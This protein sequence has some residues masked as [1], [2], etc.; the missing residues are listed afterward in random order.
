MALSTLVLEGTGLSATGPTYAGLGYPSGN[1]AGSSAADA[2]A[3]GWGAAHAGA[4][5]LIWQCCRNT[6]YSPYL[7]NGLNL[8]LPVGHSLARSGTWKLE[9][10]WLGSDGSYAGD[11]RPLPDVEMA[12]S[13]QSGVVRYR[14]LR[15]PVLRRTPGGIVSV[16]GRMVHCLSTDNAAVDALFEALLH[17]DEPSLRDPASVVRMTLLA[18]DEFDV[19]VLDG[20]DPV[21]RAGRHTTL[22]LELRRPTGEF[23]RRS[24]AEPVAVTVPVANAPLGGSVVVGPSSGA[25]IMCTVSPTGDVPTPGYA[26]SC[27]TDADGRARVRF[28]VPSAAAH[29]LRRGR[30]T[31]RLFIDR[32][33]D[34]SHDSKPGHESAVHLDVDV[35]KAISY[36]A[37][38]DSYSSGEAG[39]DDAP[40]FVGHYITDN[41][42]GKHCRRWSEAYPVVIAEELLND[43]VL[44]I[45]VSFE[46]F[47]CTGAE[48]VNTYD[49]GDPDHNGTE[50]HLVG[51]RRPSIH[52]PSVGESGWEPRQVVSLEDAHSLAHV[53]MVTV[54][55]GGND[56]GFADVL[57][58]CAFVV[59]GAGCGEA[60]LPGKYKV[61]EPRVRLALTA[62]RNAAPTASIFVLGYP[63]LM[64]HLAG[65]G[66]VT[67]E[68][69]SKYE[70]SRNSQI[71]TLL[72][73]STGCVSAIVDFVDF[74]EGDRCASLRA[75]Q[76]YHAQP[77]FK[78][79]I[80]DLLAYRFSSSLNIEASEAVFL[81]GIAD[82]INAKI[83][84][85]AIDA[86]VH[87]VDVTDT[88]SSAQVPFDWRSHSP[89]GAVP[90]I[91]GFIADK[92]TSDGKSSA[93]FHPTVA[94]HRTYAAI[95]ENYLRAAVSG[96]GAT[97]S[98]AGL[99][100]NPVP[101]F[102][103][104][105]GS[106]A[107]S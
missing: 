22:D 86:G 21:S 72:G 5:R 15:N 50:Q 67:P 1:W 14:F 64:P 7:P 70:G 29:A 28:R 45:D 41:P 16:P 107:G 39:R 74:V 25:K 47:A 100:I 48:T 10:R 99:P 89:C 68:T 54:T 63:Y 105:S 27:V 71:L 79:V 53:D 43:G 8:M 106:G 46:T 40:S 94:G 73:L 32:D 42:A 33:R 31:L 93:S 76:I 34:G 102:G 56:A 52:A 59:T 19:R 55:V 84:G 69:V 92:R 20:S 82:A 78:G 23:V 91:N 24:G 81:N 6:R 57:T 66:D 4:P 30:D 37:L 85:A 26:S 49:S 62:I 61:V 58:A 75:N 96:P 104:T 9:A 44:N 83:K 2:V 60:D 51:T 38:G 95:L 13:S 3:D 12:C 90:W 35:A 88:Q 36:I 97:L 17:Y 87:F 103:N 98:G 65:C 11:W 18:A 77:D 80:A 101:S